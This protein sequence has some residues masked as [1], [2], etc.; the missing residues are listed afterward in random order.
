YFA[1]QRSTA[2]RVVVHRQR[3]GGAAPLIGCQLEGQRRV[4]PPCLELWAERFAAAIG[5]QKPEQDEAEIAVD[6][7]GA[8][9]II[10][11]HDA[12]VVLEFTA[13]LR[14]RVDQPR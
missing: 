12:D 10:E 9:R 2:P 7:S 13:A 3:W 5:N 11:P 14:R 1:G 6:G 4:R 8:P